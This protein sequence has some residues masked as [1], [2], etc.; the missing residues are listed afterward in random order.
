MSSLVFVYG[1]L[2]EGFSNF[3]VNSGTRVPGEFVTAERYPLYVL[4][5]LHLPWLIDTPGEGHHVVGQL[6]E[7]DAT[8]LARMD[9]LEQV[10]DPRWYRRATMLV[11]RKSDAEAAATAAMVYFGSDLALQTEVVHFGPVAEYTRL[12]DG[13]YRASRL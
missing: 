7:V 8:G 4:G 5:Q 11:R 3:A 13:R 1:T 6:F 12:H 10:D 9:L 2:K